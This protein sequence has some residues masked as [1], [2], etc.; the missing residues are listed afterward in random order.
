MNSSKNIRGKRKRI[1]MENEKRK[2]T[3]PPPPPSYC[4]E[5]RWIKLFFPLLKGVKSRT[6]FEYIFD[7][8]QPLFFKVICKIYCYKF[9]TSWFYVKDEF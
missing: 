5:Q 7:T 9:Y 1:F 8:S 4:I 6:S 3:F 2:D